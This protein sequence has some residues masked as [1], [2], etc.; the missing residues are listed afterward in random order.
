MEAEFVSRYLPFVRD[1]V[2]VRLL[3]GEKIK[4]TLA[5]AVQMFTSQNQVS[6][7][8]RSGPVHDRYVF[9]R[10]ARMPPVWRVVQRWR[11]GEGYIYLSNRRR[12]Q[13]HVRYI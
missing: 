7:E 11:N 1:E 2:G 10:S 8:I 4:K 12:L 3:V 6:V 13:R 5:P 9:H